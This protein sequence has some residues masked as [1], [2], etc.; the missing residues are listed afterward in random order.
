MYETVLIISQIDIT[1]LGRWV[2]QDQDRVRIFR[3][4]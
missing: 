3:A 4:G 1:G 2:I